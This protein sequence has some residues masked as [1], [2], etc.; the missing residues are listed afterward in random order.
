MGG[1]SGIGRL[2]CEGALW[3][4]A[5]LSFCSTTLV[6]TWLV[7]GI[8]ALLGLLAA[9][10][11]RWGRLGGLQNAFEAV[12]GFIGGFVDPEGPV[13]AMR[14]RRLLY[15]FLLT[16]FFFI[17]VSNLFDVIPPYIAPTNTLNTAGAL[18]V[19]VFFFV[20][21]SGLVRHK[22]R[23]GR[24]FLHVPGPT[25][26]LFLIFTIIEELSKVLTLSFRL[27][28]NIF[29]GEV[30][31]AILLYLVR[32]THYYAGGFIVHVGWLVFSIFVG[33]VQAFIFMI[34][35][36]SYVNQVT[37]AEEHGEERHAVQ[38]AVARR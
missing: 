35:T 32:G 11:A 38:A 10:S 33:V 13:W 21:A 17:L 30:L 15:E 26:F 36:F 29:A 19:L 24:K 27:F 5:H 9:G 7:M 23:Y 8:V 1:L 6:Q 37:S 2:E 3:H 14:T 22:H 16:L 25:G 12:M 20:H 4:W 31:I 18:A 34:L 28:G